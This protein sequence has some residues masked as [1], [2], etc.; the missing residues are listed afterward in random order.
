VRSPRSIVLVAAACFLGCGEQ[1]Q[2]QSTF[3]LGILASEASL[4]TFTLS[5]DNLQAAPKLDLQGNHLIKT[6]TTRAPLMSVEG[7]PFIVRVMS[8]DGAEIS[9]LEITP[10][11]CESDPTFAEKIEAGWHGTETLQVYLQPDGTLNPENEFD[12]PLTHRCDWVS[13]DGMS[14]E[15]LETLN[16]SPT[17]C[18]EADRLGTALTA[19]DVSGL[20]EDYPLGVT[21]CAAYHYQYSAPP[22]VAGVILD[23]FAIVTPLDDAP[24]VLSLSHCWHIGE[25]FPATIAAQDAAGSPCAKEGISIQMGAGS[26]LTEVV[27]SA[28]SWT[29]QNG[30]DLPGGGHQLADVDL[31]FGTPRTGTPAYTVS[32]HID[33]PIVK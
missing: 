12:R 10:F 6:F 30:P 15:G 14:G 4:E 24:A 3:V 23:Q 33:L 19:V 32:G 9:T 17:L 26:S 8:A 27:A 13:P 5:A 29:L 7:K 25:S 16:R 11:V 20:S 21:T 2:P 31:T 22:D 1:H 18:T 28:G